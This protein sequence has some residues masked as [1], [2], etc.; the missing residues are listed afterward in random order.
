MP[1]PDLPSY[2]KL[3]FPS[4][5]TA[6]F[7]YKKKKKPKTLHFPHLALSRTL[8]PTSCH[9]PDLQPVEMILKFDSVLPYLC[10]SFWPHALH[11]CNTEKS[12]L[13]ITQYHSGKYWTGQIPAE[14]QLLHP[15]HT[16]DTYLCK[17]SLLYLI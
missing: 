2:Q 3:F 6:L 7:V 17:T 10:V 1:S 11:K 16:S 12:V 8:H 14:P 9:L 5:C 15:I 4:L 13:C